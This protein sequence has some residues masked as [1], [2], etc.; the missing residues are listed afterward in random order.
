[1]ALEP[2]AVYERLAIVFLREIGGD[3]D[4]DVRAHVMQLLHNVGRIT[5]RLWGVGEGRQRDDGVIFTVKMELKVSS[6]GI[7]LL[8]PDY[9]GDV[10]QSYL[11]SLH[12]HTRKRGGVILLLVFC[13]RESD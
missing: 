10:T 3:A 9:L 6:L 5:R 8:G 2:F 11:P 13:E 4:G 7:G 12:Q 1:M